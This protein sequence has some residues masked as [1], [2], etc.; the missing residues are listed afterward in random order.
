MDKARA[1]VKR[2]LEDDEDDV[3]FRDIEPEDK[4]DQYEKWI[5]KYKPVKNPFEENTG[6]DGCLFEPYS[7]ES[8]YITSLKPQY[9][10]TL[11]TDDNDSEVICA[12]LH[13]VNREGYFVTEVPWADSSEYYEISPEIEPVDQIIDYILDNALGADWKIKWSGFSQDQKMAAFRAAAE[14][15]DL[16]ADPVKVLSC[17]DKFVNNA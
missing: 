5:R 6:Y 17:I 2:I 8:R 4:P 10:W 1:I 14:E 7:T 13:F 15:L 3:E 11:V 12:G 16:V 9:V